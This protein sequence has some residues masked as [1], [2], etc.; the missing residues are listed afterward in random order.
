[1]EELSDLEDVLPFLELW[2]SFQLS[3]LT[4]SILLKEVLR[5][6]RRRDT[7]LSGTVAQDL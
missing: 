5:M 1:M 7:T 4:D 6:L 3:N 2:T